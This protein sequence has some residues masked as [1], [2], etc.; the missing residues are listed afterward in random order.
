VAKLESISVDGLLQ[1]ALMSFIPNSA[2]FF[3]SS[4]TDLTPA[5]RITSNPD[6]LNENFT[7]IMGIL[8]IKNER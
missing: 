8:D 6:D 2:L 5:T 1:T 3:S 4:V 7:A